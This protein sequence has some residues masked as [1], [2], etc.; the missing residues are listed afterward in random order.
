[1]RCWLLALTLLGVSAGLR[2]AAQPRPPTADELALFRDAMK[3]STQDTEHWAYTES[4]RITATKGSPK[5]ETIVRFDPS[6]PYAEQF[7]PIKVEGQPP[8]EKQLK[9][10]R[11]RGE[12]RGERVARAA[13][14]AR[15][16]TRPS[17][18]PQLRVSGQ[19]MTL[20]LEHP[21]VGSVEEKR[22]AFEVP[23]QGNNKDIPVDKF[24][25][26]VLVGKEARLVEHVTLRLRESFRVKLIAKVKAGEA[27]MDFT[28]VDPKF[29]PVISSMTGNFD[30]SLLFIPV[31]ATF[32]RT[33]T[34][35]Q[36]VK[37]FDE[38]LKVRL[39][40]LQFPDF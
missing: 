19:N 13:E 23:L 7:T 36:R 38:R 3:N 9:D 35:W 40:P 39:G 2:A 37:S 6:K 20:D 26:Q 12:R 18:Q 30:V 34:D 25:I 5:G 32:T 31:N 28:V 21:R 11:R 1:M 4:T 33:R 22:I 8:S 27:Q 15:D 14:A 16:P 10:Y 24:Q 17:R 29:G